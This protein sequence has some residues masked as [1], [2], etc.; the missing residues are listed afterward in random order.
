MIISV[1]SFTNGAAIPDQYAY[2]KPDTARHTAYSEN[3]NPEI[4]WSELPQGTQSLALLCVDDQVP[5]TFEQANQEGKTIAAETPRTDFYHW[6][7]INID[8]KRHRIKAGEDSDGIV[9]GG[10]PAGHRPYGV[11]GLNSY[12]SGKKIQ[13]GYDGP[14]P[15]WNDERMHQYHFKLYALDIPS[16]QLDGNF[17]GP[18]VLTAMKGHVLAQANWIGLYTL[19]PAL[20]N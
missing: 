1:P 15:P 17:T 11:V 18:D 14:C 13:A 16:L 3:K 5:T 9:A 12:S 4:Q 6:V 7:V 2:C 10:K 20:R 19:N 8:P